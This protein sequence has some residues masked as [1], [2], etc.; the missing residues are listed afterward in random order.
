MYSHILSL[1]GRWSLWNPSR[2]DLS[3]NRHGLCIYFLREKDERL[4]ENMR[5]AWDLRRRAHTPTSSSLPCSQQRQQVEQLA[6]IS[7][8]FPLPFSSSLQKPPFPNLSPGRMRLKFIPRDQRDWCHGR[9]AMGPHCGHGWDILGLV[10]ATEWIKLCWPH[11]L[12][13]STLFLHSCSPCC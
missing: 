8:H 6:K 2:V 9:C 5:R 4:P 3:T 13:H 10:D 11:A 7:S 1:P 12:L